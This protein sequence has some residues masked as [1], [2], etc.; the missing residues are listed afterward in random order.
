MKNFKTQLLVALSIT[1]LASP[2]FAEAFDISTYFAEINLAGVATAIGALALLI[3]GICM[4]EKGISV[5]KRVIQK[6]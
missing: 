1:S 2:A 6:L 5:A 3:I 4:S